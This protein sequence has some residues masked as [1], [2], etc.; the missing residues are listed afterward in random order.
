MRKA[1]VQHL[2]FERDQT[3][4]SSNGIFSEACMNLLFIILTG[5][6]AFR[7]VIYSKPS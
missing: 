1:F 5:N 7:K 6:K 2:K 3:I 4:A